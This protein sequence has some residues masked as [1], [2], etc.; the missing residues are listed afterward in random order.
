M[1]GASIERQSNGLHASVSWP[2]P[3]I[4]PN[5]S[6]NTLRTSLRISSDRTPTNSQTSGKKMPL[7][8]S[9]NSGSKESIACKSPTTTEANEV[10]YM[11][12]LTPL[13]E[14]FLQTLG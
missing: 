8:R 14:E 3:R 6:D 1:V 7:L 9:I 11:A 10:Q 12:T 13:S 5:F 4:G 2:I